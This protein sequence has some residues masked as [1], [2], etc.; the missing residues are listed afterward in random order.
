MDK[1]SPRHTAQI[2][3][4]P[5]PLAGASGYRHLSKQNHGRYSD[6]A[7]KQISF[8]SC[9]YHEEALAESKMSRDR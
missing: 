4:F 7:V 5:S 3:Q 8:G 9:W 6:D 2:L 1:H